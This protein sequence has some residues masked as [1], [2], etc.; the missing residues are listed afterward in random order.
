MIFIYS[1]DDNVIDILKHYNTINQNICFQFAFFEKEYS[2]G[3]CPSDLPK[4][5]LK[6][7]LNVLNEWLIFSII[8][9]IQDVNLSLPH[10]DDFCA[11]RYVEM[12]VWT[13]PLCFTVSCVNDSFGYVNGFCLFYFYIIGRGKNK[14]FALKVVQIQRC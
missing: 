9:Y 4:I 10:S 13:V 6:I 2:S 8:R 5:G 14:I 1:N 7:S 12:C 11:S 3:G